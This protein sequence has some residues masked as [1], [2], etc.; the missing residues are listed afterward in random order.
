[1]SPE[2]HRQVSDISARAP[3]VAREAGIPVRIDILDEA[4]AGRAQAEQFIHDQYA[5]AYGAD[6]RHFL[7]RLMCLHTEAGELRAALGFRRARGEQLFLENYLDVAVERALHA[8][9]G[10]AVDRFSLVEVGNLAVA[11][12]GGARWLIAALTSYLKAAGY[13]WA[14]F[15]AVSA[16]RNAF[17]RLGVNLTVL[18]PATAARLAPSERAGWGRYYDTRPLV[19]AANV[20]Q[21]FAAIS[22]SL[23]S[24]AERRTLQAMWNHAFATGLSHAA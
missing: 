15:T 11:G 5:R 9:T 23:D 8:G 14:V 17:E 7:P 3:L 4:G 24:N 1:M 10:Q 12:A 18:A 6:V 20:H 13:D 21:S 16:L 2:T 19:V 22:C